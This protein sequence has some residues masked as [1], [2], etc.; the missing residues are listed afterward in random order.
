VADL[1]IDVGRLAPDA[2]VDAIAAFLSE[3]GARARP[4]TTPCRL[5]RARMISTLNR[6]A[7]AASVRRCAG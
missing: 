6:A 2:A 4:A 7:W 5:V 1:R 3:S